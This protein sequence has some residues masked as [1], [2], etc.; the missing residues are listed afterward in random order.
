MKQPE[1]VI[2]IPAYNEAQ[3]IA[4]VIGEI[5]IRHKL[6]IIVI[7]DGS[8]DDT[9]TQATNAGAIVLRHAINRGKGAAIKTGIAAAHELQAKSIIT[10]DADGQH[11][12]RDIEILIKGLNDGYDV[13]LGVRN[14]KKMP[15]IKQIANTIGNIATLL[16]YGLW[17]QDSQ[18]GLRA[19]SQKA[20]ERITTQNERYEYESEVIRDIVRHK[21]KYIEVPVKTTY[22]SYSQ[23][24]KHKQN[25]VNGI[26]TIIHMFYS[27]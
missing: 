23:T 27:S 3:V 8:D 11:D 19:F 18:C 5:F 25:F 16:F 21:L 24:K 6:P 9:S 7:D 4:S 13:V 15:F 1:V 22:T 10:F 12:P 17:V 20:Y 14:Q 26:R 2:L